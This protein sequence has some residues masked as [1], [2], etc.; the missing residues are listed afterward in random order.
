MPDEIPPALSPRQWH[1]GELRHLVVLPDG[2]VLSGTARVSDDDPRLVEI[3]GLVQGKSGE[4]MR[5]VLPAHGLAALALNSLPTGFTR[6]MAEAIRRTAEHSEACALEAKG[7]FREAH[8][9]DARLAR[10]AAEVIESL[11]PP[12]PGG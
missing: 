2:G 8:D 4:R 1:E 3:V 5:C 10:R 9:E 7:A 12:E 6:A 11:L